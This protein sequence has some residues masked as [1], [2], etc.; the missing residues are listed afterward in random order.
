MNDYKNEILRSKSYKTPLN[1]NLCCQQIFG[2]V[3]FSRSL[4]LLEKIGSPSFSS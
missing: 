2:C 1:Q 3:T 4:V